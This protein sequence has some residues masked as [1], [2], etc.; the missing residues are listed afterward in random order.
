MV[1]QDISEVMRG[2]CEQNHTGE[3]LNFSQDAVELA[4]RAHQIIGML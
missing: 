2:D 4:A 3:G 1:D